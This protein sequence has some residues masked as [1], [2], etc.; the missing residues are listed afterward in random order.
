[1]TSP[2][3]V[4]GGGRSG[5][6]LRTL[7]EP[8]SRL[9]TNS[10][11][12]QPDCVSWPTRGPDM[13]GWSRSESSVLLAACSCECQRSN[14]YVRVLAGLFVAG[15]FVACTNFD[16]DSACAAF[17]LVHDPARGACR[18]PD[19]T[20]PVD[21]EVPDGGARCLPPDGGL[22]DGCSPT[23]YFAD[24]DRDGF[25][26]AAEFI[27]SCEQPEGFVVNGFDCDDACRECGPSGVESCDGRRD[28]DCDATVDEGCDCSSGDSRD[29]L[30][31][32]NEGACRAGRQDCF[33][34][35]WSTC[36][37]AVGPT[38]EVCDGIDNDCD[39]QVD[40]IVA[41]ASCGPVAN[42]V[43]STCTAGTCIVAMCS[44]G[45]LDCDRSFANGCERVL[46]TLEACTSCGSSCGWECIDGGCDDP[47]AIYSG[48][49][50]SC[51]VRDSGG[52]LCWGANDYYQ[53]G[54]GTMVSTTQPVEVPMIGS[55]VSVGM[56]YRHTCAV[57]LGGALSC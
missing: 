45:N 21:G 35:V 33:A 55:P 1:M 24:R 3:L 57:S 17:G 32:T 28:E 8:A 11:R 46:G 15:A 4:G 12:F 26:N 51:L 2:P 31:G 30:G 53:L 25:G 5:Y 44:E 52:F 19:G 20:L 47:I 39:G 13:V 37:G 38:V 42:T 40:G 54:D 10:V 7:P 14:M 50:Q 34:G 18:C 49:F 22:G 6:G 36:V 43:A 23:R 27:D 41:A 29:C 16:A 9:N 56:G 48:D